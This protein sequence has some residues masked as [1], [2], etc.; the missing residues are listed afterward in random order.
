[1]RWT[2]LL[3]L[4]KQLLQIRLRNGTSQLLHHHTQQGRV[5]FQLRVASSE[6]QRRHHRHRPAAPPHPTLH[7]PLALMVMMTIG[8]RC[9]GVAPARAAPAPPAAAEAAAPH[10][11]AD[12]LPAATAAAA[13]L[14]DEAAAAA[15]ALHDARDGTAVAAARMTGTT[16]AA[17]TAAAAARLRVTPAATPAP[18]GDTGSHLMTRDQMPGGSTPVGVVLLVAGGV[19]M[20]QGNHSSAA[21]HHPHTRTGQGRRSRIRPPACSSATCHPAG[22]LMIWRR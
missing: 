2:N 22:R 21:M 12:E 15:G 11:T 9:T 6:R 10:D 8:R 17:A 5:L 16:V 20:C 3:S 7:S 13:A 1:M 14:C 4:L 19:G 18:R